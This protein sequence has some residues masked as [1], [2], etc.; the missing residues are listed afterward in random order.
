MSSAFSLPLL[1]HTWLLLTCGSIVVRFTKSL[2]IPQRVR[3][4]SVVQSPLK[5]NAKQLLLTLGA[6]VL[7]LATFA[8]GYAVYPLLHGASAPALAASG[9]G[10]PG[11]GA[12]DDAPRDLGVFW[13]AWRLLDGNFY[14]EQ[15]DDQARVYGAVR[16]LA[17]AYGDPY[18]LFVEPQPRE[19]ERDQMRGSFGGIGATVEITGT[20]ILLHP[21]PDQ[22]AARAGVQD[23]DE[24]LRVDGAAVSGEM[25]SDAVVAL[26]RGPVGSTVVLTLRR[27]SGDSNQELAQELEVG[28]ERAEIQ[29]PSMEWRILEGAPNVG[30]IRHTIFSERSPQ[31][32]EQ[33]IAELAEA[34][35]DRFIWDLRGNPGGLLDS[36]IALADLWLDEG[37]VLVQESAGGASKTFTS[38]D[39]GVGRD[40]PLVVVVDAGSASASEIVAGALQDRGRAR[41]VG[42]RTFG[43]G[44]VQSIYELADQSSL[45]VT[46]AQ[47]FTPN[48][49]KI[50]GEGLAPDIAVE[51]GTDPLPA[52]VAAM[53]ASA[54]LGHGAPP[55]EE[56]EQAESEAGS[57]P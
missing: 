47:W 53:D 46:S 8:A 50:S 38:A 15:P 45:H 5:M 2:Y 52:A 11:S 35:A 48:R 32:M 17:G 21:L 22:P 24:L 37:A 54:A 49:R 57:I 4:N 3:L 41:L 51:P 1:T 9:M 7:L 44:S 20:R 6:L 40:Y 28:V 16:G 27:V 33:A 19:L 10:D 43:K 39:G 12:A 29:T 55:A 42:E 26:I 13:E 36:A 56:E 30:Y 34:G 18:T 31:E 25:S 23:G 14:G